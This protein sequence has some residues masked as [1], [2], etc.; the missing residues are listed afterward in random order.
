MTDVVDPPG[1]PDDA[2]PPP[3]RA[4]VTRRGR[5]VL[6]FFA[7]I[8]VVGLGAGLWLLRQINPSGG[9]GEKVAV[10]IVPG[11]SVS[12][13]ATKLEDEGVITSAQIFR[14]YLKVG[15][16]AGSIQAGEYEL[17][18]NL[19][20]GEVKAALRR[21]PSIKFQKLTIPEALTLEKIADKVGELPGRSRDKFLAAAR[22][23]EVRSKYQ[24]PG[25]TNLEGLLFPDTYLLTDKEDETAIVRRLV[26]RFDQV[27]D[28]VGI[29]TAGSD[30]GGQVKPPSL[31]V[32]QLIVAASLAESEAK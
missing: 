7:V 6:G 22:S 17:R 30:Q 32:Y 10:D 31:G 14:L 23:G 4:R 1:P 3:R 2:S 15:G 21:G 8:L 25:N 19:S 9:P 26:G 12:G 28:E 5:I 24:P 27:A 18:K 29:A 13:V 16:G 20:M 11:T